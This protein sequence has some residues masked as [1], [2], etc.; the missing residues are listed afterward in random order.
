MMAVLSAAPG[1]FHVISKDCL[2]NPGRPL[3]EAEAFTAADAHPHSCPGSIPKHFTKAQI[4]R[5]KKLLSGNY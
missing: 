2:W 4:A 5:A 3:P 1:T